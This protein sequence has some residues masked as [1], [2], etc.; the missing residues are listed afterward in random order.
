MNN[1]KYTVSDTPFEPF[2]KFASGDWVY[3]YDRKTQ[4]F[5]NYE[6]ISTKHVAI[7]IECG[8]NTPNYNECVEKIIRLYLSSSEEFDLIN[9]AYRGEVEKYEAWLTKLDEIKKYVKN[10]FNNYEFN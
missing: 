1:P 4:D 7:Y 5:T 9:S 3:F 10:D 2:H 6:E 8:K